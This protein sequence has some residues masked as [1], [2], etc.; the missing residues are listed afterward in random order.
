[1]RQRFFNRA[2]T[3]RRVTL[4]CSTYVALLFLLKQYSIIT[5]NY[6]F[7]GVISY[8]K[9]INGLLELRLAG[10]RWSGLTNVVRYDP[11]N[12]LNSAYLRSIE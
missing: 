9:I 12:L 7:N 6:F 5:F 8:E 11:L 3:V 10:I 2:Y 4:E 1:M